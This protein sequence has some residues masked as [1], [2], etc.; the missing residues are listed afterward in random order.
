MSLRMHLN[1]CPKAPR[2]GADLST[3][4]PVI[5]ETIRSFRAPFKE[6]KT[7]PLNRLPGL[8]AGR[9]LRNVCVKNESKR[10]GLNAFKVLGGPH[11]TGGCLAHK[12]HL[13]LQN[14][15]YNSLETPAPQARFIRRGQPQ[16]LALRRSAIL[17]RAPREA[18]GPAVGR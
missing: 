16:L 18:L 1:S 5:A 6:Y 8:A 7:T 14:P 3:L 15:T 10:F 12:I 9:G 4:P 11:P 17:W 13:P 2:A